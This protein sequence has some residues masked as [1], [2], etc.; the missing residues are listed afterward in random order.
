MR[1]FILLFFLGIASNANGQPIQS[2]ALVP[3]A[4]RQAGNE[5][6]VPYKIIYA[7]AMV[8]SSKRLKSANIRR[9]WPWTLNIEKEAHYFTTKQEAVSALTHYLQSGKQSIAVGIMQIY[10]RWHKDKLSD[11]RMALDPHYNLRLGTAYLREMFN[12]S[13]D[14]WQAVG[15]YHIKPRN[16]GELMQQTYYVAAVM[17]EWSKLR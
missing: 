6:G 16:Q 11:P 15:D 17:K 14:W 8:E 7:V 5:H 13:G 12:E 9:P 3:E 10:W 1:N 4:Y 2:A